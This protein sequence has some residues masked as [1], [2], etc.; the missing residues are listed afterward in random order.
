MAE[1]TLT[2]ELEPGET[3][4]WQGQPAAGRGV[5]SNGW[6]WF[7]LMVLAAVTL[8]LM[9]IGLMIWLPLESS[10]AAL[11]MPLV[12]LSAFATFLALKVSVLDRRRARARDRVTRF[13]LTE[14]RALARIGPYRFEIPLSPATKITYREDELG[15]LI[16]QAEGCDPLSFDRLE[17]ARAAK[18]IATAQIEA[19]FEATA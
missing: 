3:L 9:A 19:Q 5:S 6:R 8:F 12:A 18:D 2:N 7:W 1:M 4:L 16:F 14:R 11:P 13:G 17:D 10:L 15:A